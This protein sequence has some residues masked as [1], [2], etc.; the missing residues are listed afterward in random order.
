MGLEKKFTLGEKVTI[1]GR[2]G[3]YKVAGHDTDAL[4]VPVVPLR[5]GPVE[6]VARGLL[7]SVP[8]PARPHS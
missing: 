6:K 3:V 8:A 1:E 2:P 5:D 4:R 7:S